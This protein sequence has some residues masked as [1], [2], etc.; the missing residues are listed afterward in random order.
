[1]K[2]DSKQLIDMSNAVRAGALHALRCAASG[3]A[4][5][6][7]GAADVVTTIY[8]NHLRRDTDEFIL[9]AGHGSALLYSTL[10]LA[11]YK[12]HPLKTFRKQGGL[13]GH[14]EYGIDGVMATT[15]PLGQGLANA[16]GIALA[17]KIKKARREKNS[18]GYVYC[19]C[20]DGDLMEGIA[21]EAIAF[22]GRYKLD[23]LVV[24]W[25]DNGISIDGDALTDLDVP[26]RMQA[27]GWNVLS[28]AGHDF[29]GI[30][31]ALG[32]AL[33]STAPTF[34][35]CKTV[36]GAGSSL[37]GTPQAHALGLGAQELIGLEQHS[38]TAT[39]LKLWAKVAKHPA[40]KIKSNSAE[41]KVYSIGE[42]WAGDGEISTR[43]LSGLFLEKLLGQEPSMLGGSADLADS[44][45]TRTPAHK[46][47]TP[48]DFSGNFINYGVRE[49]AMAA[50][51]NGLCVAG[52]RPY[53]GTFLVFSDYMRPAVRLAALSK[54]PTIFVFSHDSVGVGE[55]G[56]THQPVEQ[57]ASLRLI[58]NLNVFRPC[59]AA[60]VAACWEV[61]LADAHSPSC[62]VT[63]R[64]KFAQ[65]ATPDV[66]K[67]KNGA[68][69]IKSSNTRRPKITL[70]ATGSEVPLAVKVAEKFKSAQ[71][72]SMPSVEKFRAM[73]DKYK[74]SVLAGYVVAIEAGATGGWL[75]FA[76]AVMGIDKFGSTGPGKDVLESFGFNAEIIAAEIAKRLK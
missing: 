65:I 62:I 4:G 73:D 54:I 33:K 15:G 59:N 76:D 38:P 42:Y 10:K 3:H 63:S 60:E 23:N 20:S 28:T 17:K 70:V 51:M 55:D 14:P 44:T 1:M 34:I 67:I 52:F 40:V 18:D 74:K 37:A 72:V 36:L 7:L 43:E 22:A 56:P 45:K 69:I 35:L 19:L 11:G 41:A 48:V 31:R 27:A 68:Y 13:P 12:I 71:V 66:N 46:D 75:E 58:P 26:G 25:D 50:I 8:A 49:H 61:A 16:V 6:A 47:I 32:S 57:L 24:L 5:I 2:F 53:G 30:D 64:Q 39:G 21:Q 29:K 9:S